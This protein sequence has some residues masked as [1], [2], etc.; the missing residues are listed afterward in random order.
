MRTVVSRESTIM[1]KDL[2]RKS[3]QLQ[4]MSKG[5]F[6][7]LRLLYLIFTRLSM[8]MTWLN[9]LQNLS[10]HIVIDCSVHSVKLHGM[11]DW[12]GM[13]SRMALSIDGNNHNIN[14]EDPKIK[15]MKLHKN[16][17]ELPF[18][19]RYC[20]FKPSW[21]MFETLQCGHNFCKFRCSRPTIMGDVRDS[22]M[23]SQFL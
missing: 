21:E 23:W 17:I 1:P 15:M 9:P 2:T 12:N 4:K 3:T 11:V 22:L 19:G 6:L 5:N 7:I 14:N 20:D 10:V 13:W 18:C 8:T 16:G